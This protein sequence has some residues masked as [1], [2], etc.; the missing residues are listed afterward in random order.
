MRS[1]RNGTVYLALDDDFLDERVG[2]GLWYGS[3]Q[4]SDGAVEEGPSFT[5]AEDAVSWWKKRGATT[6]LIRLDFHEYLGAGEGHP[7]EGS[8]AMRIFD[9]EDSR[10]RPEGAR[11]T[12]E[13]LR[14]AE[15]E[16]DRAEQDAN[17][18][19]EG[20]RLSRRRETVGLTVEELA[21]RVGEPPKWL[22]DVE[23]GLSTQS[24]TLSQWIML[25]WATRPGWPEEMKKVEP[26]RIGWVARK[27][28]FLNE[29]EAMVNRM[30]G[31][32]V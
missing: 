14:R 12:I 24:V 27:G 21:E 4:F 25:V 13:T 2:E 18:I 5:D 16:R 15:A 17:A 32:D 9:P 1:V 28:Q 20:E 19:A 7:F 22:L 11:K 10:G 29:A 30:L 8:E 23:S 26:R 31:F 3:C 6:I